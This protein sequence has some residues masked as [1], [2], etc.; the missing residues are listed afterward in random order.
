MGTTHYHPPTVPHIHLREG[1]CRTWAKSMGSIRDELTDR[2][3][4]PLS[5][6]PSRRSTVDCIGLQREFPNKYLSWSFHSPFFCSTFAPS[7]YLQYFKSNQ[8]VLVTYTYLADA[9]MGVAKSL[10]F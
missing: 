5:V 2:I 10:C 9:I 4:A 6:N 8:I 1:Y 7:M 3:G